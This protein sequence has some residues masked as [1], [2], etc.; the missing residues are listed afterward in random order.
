V[1]Y[2][3]LLQ[4]VLARLGGAPPPRRLLLCVLGLLLEVG[5]RAALSRT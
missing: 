4:A 5:Q 2:G 3:A 1:G